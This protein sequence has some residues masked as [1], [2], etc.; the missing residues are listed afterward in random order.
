MPIVVGHESGLGPLLGQLAY[1]AGTGAL[2]QEQQEKNRQYAL[3]QAQLQQRALAQQQEQAQFF[4]GL[5][6]RAQEAERERN[7]NIAA[8]HQEHQEYQAFKDKQ[9]QQAFDQQ[10]NLLAQRNA[11]SAQNAA[12]ATQ[13]RQQTLDHQEFSQ[14]YKSAQDTLS[15]FTKQELLPEGQALLSKHRAGLGAIIQN[16][17]LDARGKTQALGQW[18]QEIEGSGIRDMVKPPP[19]IQTFPHPWLKNADGSPAQLPG[20][21]ERRNGSEKTVFASGAEAQFIKDRD[22]KA[23]ATEKAKQSTLKYEHELRT[24]YKGMLGPGN[25]PL[26][27]D[28]IDQRVAQEMNRKFGHPLP[29]PK[30]T[31]HPAET[32]IEMLTQLGQ[33]AAEGQPVMPAAPADATPATAGP[34]SNARLAQLERDAAS[35]LGYQHAGDALAHAQVMEQRQAGTG[36]QPTDLPAG[37][38]QVPGRDEG[39][40]P[41]ADI[42]ANVAD[43]RRSPGTEMG[44]LRKSYEDRRAAGDEGVQP[45]D[46]PE[47]PK[48][49]PPP[50][51]ADHETAAAKLPKGAKYTVKLP[52]GR[53]AVYEVD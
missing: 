34:P 33:G 35:E 28:E 24:F 22:A 11:M 31:P 1:Q 46:L 2:A 16:R 47:R 7:A 6:Y 48:E 38:P 32:F 21:V 44:K 8:K 12:T 14:I 26:T 27:I 37:E 45:D 29:P 43:P 13:S 49:S 3:Q 5:Q 19:Q 42:L 36:G 30:P 17:N 39:K 9:Q 15:A 25:V 53:L 4:A 23:N 41:W 18:M 52:N 10:T 20:Y 40:R 50:E 51:F